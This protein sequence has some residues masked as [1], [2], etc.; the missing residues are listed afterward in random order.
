VQTKI[1]GL[2]EDL[3]EPAQRV[4][5]ALKMARRK[6]PVGSNITEIVSTT[7]LSRYTVVRVLAVLHLKGSVK[8]QKVGMAKV[9]RLSGEQ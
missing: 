2:P 3:V 4:L 6:G 8:T 7:R 9:Y 5:S 1:K